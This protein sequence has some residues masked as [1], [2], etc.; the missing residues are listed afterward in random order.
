MKIIEF[1]GISG[2]G[3][4]SIKNSLIKKI[5]NKSKSC[6]D[7]REILTKFLPLEEKN[8]SKKLILKLYLNLKSNKKNI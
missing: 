2:S 5:K 3:K 8:L 1:F 4:T 6:Y 7:Y